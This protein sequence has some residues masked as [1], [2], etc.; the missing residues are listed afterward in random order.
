M[1]AAISGLCPL[2]Q[3]K[4]TKHTHRGRHMEIKLPS[5]PKEHYHCK[6]LGY[7][8]LILKVWCPQNKLEGAG[9]PQGQ[10]GKEEA[11]LWGSG[12]GVWTGSGSLRAL[13]GVIR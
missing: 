2:P 8:W 11:G 13:C 6:T 7:Q 12:P 4:N 5:V 10:V 9:S 1:N 3:P